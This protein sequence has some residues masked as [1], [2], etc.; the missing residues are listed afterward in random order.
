[1]VNR[2]LTSIGQR[3]RKILTLP[4]II[5]FLLSITL[6]LSPIIRYRSWNVN[7][8]WFHWIGFVVWMTAYYFL[9]NIIV[10]SKFNSDFILLASIQL[11]TGIGLITVWSLNSFFGFRQSIWLLF[12]SAISGLLLRNQRILET[13]KNFKYLLLISGLGLI[14]L[15]FFFGTYPGGIGPNLWL[16]LGG[17]FFQPSELLKII[18][19]IYLAAYFSGKPIVHSNY[20]QFILPTA[21]LVFASIALLV[22]QRD[23]GTALIFISIYILILFSVYGKRRILLASFCL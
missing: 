13:L 20:F 8:R 10:K 23:F 11:I 14:V 1:M 12:C 4:V 7:L 19:I 22:F 15:T 18:L 16:E 21:V 3:E 17:I 6:T 5:V 2:F 9:A